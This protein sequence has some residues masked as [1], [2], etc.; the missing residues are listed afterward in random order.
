M[1]VNFKD[2]CAAV[3]PEIDKLFNELLNPLL[4]TAA[5]KDIETLMTI[6]CAGKKIR[7]CMLCMVNMSLGGALQAALP[8]AVAIELIQAASLIHDDFVDQDAFR[9]NSPA[10]WTLEGARKAVLLGDVLFSTAI[11]MMSDLGTGAC[12]EISTAI[13]KVATGALNEPVAPD[14]LIDRMEAGSYNAGIYETIITLKSGTLFAAACKLGAVS[15]GADDKIQEI[16]RRYGSRVGEAY[17]I[18]DDL[19]EL[20]QHISTSRIQLEKMAQ[21]APALLYFSDKLKPFVMAV[22]KGDVLDLG[23]ETLSDLTRAVHLMQEE[24]QKRLLSAL[25]ELS[26]LSLKTPYDALLRKAPAEL[27]EIFSESL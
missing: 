27:I 6:L 7:G 3:K 4:E 9:R 15:A 26:E 19:Q 11:K 16:F 1:G 23:S 8:M 22:L 13:L 14:A 25:P 18:A 21:L 10:V 12:R 20:K 2:Y 17:Q 5:I 24:T